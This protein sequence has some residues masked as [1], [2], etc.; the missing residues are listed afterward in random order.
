MSAPAQRVF[1]I[2]H[3]SE[4]KAHANDLRKALERFPSAEVWLDIH[5]LKPGDRLTEIEAALRKTDIVVV[6]WSTEAATGSEWVQKEIAL[7]ERLG[8][9]IVFC[10]MDTGP[11]ANRQLD[12][13]IY[14]HYHFP[15][16]G[17]A[18]L[19]MNEIMPVLLDDA[20]AQHA[21][22]EHDAQLA[23]VTAEL[24]SPEGFY[25]N[26]YWS[27]EINRVWPELKG[28]VE[29]R[30]QRAPDRSADCRAFLDVMEKAHEGLA[31]FLKFGS[32]QETM[33]LADYIDGEGNL[34]IPVDSLQ[35]K[36]AVPD[37]EREEIRQALQGRFPSEQLN[38]LAELLHL[39]IR[40]ADD[41]LA[42]M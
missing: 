32:S 38:D 25:A 35:P 3:K 17:L 31:P 18:R 16:V 4:G 34:V 23:H 33:D 1:F 39:Y 22:T 14:I 24:L 12:D 7:A 21:L 40:D 42:A 15:E 19:C 30:A 10:V 26:D 8:V 36:R 9:K 37:R 20:R 2:S 11:A 41:N 13:R 29:A 6:L 28:H 27:A 5:H